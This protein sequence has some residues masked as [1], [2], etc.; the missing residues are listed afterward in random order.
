V[1]CCIFMSGKANTFF[2]QMNFFSCL[3][4]LMLDFVCNWTLLC[5]NCYRCV[6]SNYYLMKQVRIIKDE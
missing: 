1:Q 5:E 4:L 6:S 3:E 2:F